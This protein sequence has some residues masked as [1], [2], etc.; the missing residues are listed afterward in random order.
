MDQNQIPVNVDH[1]HGTI[2][3]GSRVWSIR[4]LA[5]CV[6][7]GEG[8]YLKVE[9]NSDQVLDLRFIPDLAAEVTR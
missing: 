4:A 6:A 9:K 8:A 1:E 7:L 3:I 2:T 5:E